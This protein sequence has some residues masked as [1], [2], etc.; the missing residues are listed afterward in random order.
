MDTM[1]LRKTGRFLWII[2]S[3]VFAIIPAWSCAMND[4]TS[5]YTEIDGLVRSS[6]DSASIKNIRLTLYP[7]ATLSVNPS[8]SCSSDSNGVFSLKNNATGSMP[9]TLS[10]RAK[11]IDSLVNGQFHDTTLMV[12][13]TESNKITNSYNYSKHIDLY[14]KYIK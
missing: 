6:T 14:M 1:S 8:D 4:S 13:V 11:D 3:L 7:A 5:T 10:I 12:I 2:S 9:E